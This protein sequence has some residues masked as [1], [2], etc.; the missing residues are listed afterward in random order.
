MFGSRLAN[1]TNPRP[2]PAG[3]ANVHRARPAPY[4][5][6]KLSVHPICERN[7]V[8]S[9]PD[10]SLLIRNVAALTEMKKWTNN[11]QDVFVLQSEPSEE[12]FLLHFTHIL[13]PF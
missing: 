5:V 3:S 1:E 10:I 12:S 13:M 8:N 9:I 11:Y 2:R 4:K 6:H 7:H